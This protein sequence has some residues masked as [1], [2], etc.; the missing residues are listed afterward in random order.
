MS[1]SLNLTINHPFSL[2]IPCFK[3]E[4]R[5]GPEKTVT[6]IYLG[7]TEICLNKEKN[8]SNESDSQNQ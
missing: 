4:A 8:K 5:K 7:K 6:Q 1:L 3:T 2:C